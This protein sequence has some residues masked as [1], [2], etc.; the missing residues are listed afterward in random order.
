MPINTDKV[1]HKYVFIFVEDK[2]KFE[3]KPL[4]HYLSQFITLE[5]LILIL[6]PCANNCP[7]GQNLSTLNV[8]ALKLRIWRQKMPGSFS[9]TATVLQGFRDFNISRQECCED[10]S[11]YW[12]EMNQE[13]ACNRNVDAGFAFFKLFTRCLF[14][15]NLESQ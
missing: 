5:L 7:T 4:S 10:Q 13:I 2:E 8:Q 6:F 12:V 9:A 14:S 1:C 15:L 11:K 3:Q